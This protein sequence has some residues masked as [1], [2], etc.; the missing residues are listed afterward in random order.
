MKALLLILLWTT[1]EGFVFKETHLSGS[2]ARNEGT[3]K[4]IR[5]RDGLGSFNN[6]GHGANMQ[7]MILFKNA[8]NSASS[9]YRND[10]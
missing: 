1:V 7:H 10:D 9:F 2:A 5:S 3:K 4:I 8:I 6:I